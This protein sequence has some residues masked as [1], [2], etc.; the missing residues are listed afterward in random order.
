MHEARVFVHE[1]LV[2]LGWSPDF[3]EHDDR[4]GPYKPSAPVPDQREGKWDIQEL[5]HANDDA[6]EGMVDERADSTSNGEAAHG[7]VIISKAWGRERHGR[8]FRSMETRSHLTGILDEVERD[9]SHVDQ[10]ASISY[11]I[12]EV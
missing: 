8:P 1:R 10:P 7:T 6:R 3:E 9:D 5:V 2:L 4:S 12:L 11:R